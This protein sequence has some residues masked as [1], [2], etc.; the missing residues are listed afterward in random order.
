MTG[1]ENIFST[2]FIAE[3][4]YKINANNSIRTE[5]QTLFTEQENGE[6]MMGMLEYSV[7]PHWFFSILDQYNYGNPAN[8]KIH[9]Y[10]GSIGY[11]KNTTRIQIS[12]GK[13]REGILCVGG[14]CRSVPASNGLTV[15][16]S[17]SF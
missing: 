12:Y 13:Q 5:I 7:A 8:M 11:V 1:H 4:N 2:I 16:I 3:T 15:S 17:S 6:W 9:Y 14:V 10:S